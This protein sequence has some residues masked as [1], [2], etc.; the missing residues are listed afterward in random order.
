VE[1]TRLPTQVRNALTAAKGAE[2]TRLW[3][4]DRARAP[5]HSICSRPGSMWLDAVP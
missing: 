2:W 5:L 1:L 3:P 4:A